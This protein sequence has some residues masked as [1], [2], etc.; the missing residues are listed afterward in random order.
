MMISRRQQR[1]FDIDWRKIS[2]EYFSHVWLSYH[3]R[4]GIHQLNITHH[5]T[6]YKRSHTRVYFQLSITE[7]CNK[8]PLQEKQAQTTPFRQRYEKKPLQKR[9]TQRSFSG[10]QL[11]IV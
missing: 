11:T 2:D 3:N 1:S 4:K 9:N 10:P 5:H 8:L 6:I 7:I